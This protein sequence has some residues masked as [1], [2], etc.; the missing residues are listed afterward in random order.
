MKQKYLAL[1][2]SALSSIALARDGTALTL[3]I[4]KVGTEIETDDCPAIGV[5]QAD[6]DFNQHV[7]YDF[8]SFRADCAMRYSQKAVLSPKT[9]L[10]KNT[11]RR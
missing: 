7:G 5:P 2:S 6:V 1:C 4:T 10:L 8:S 9:S 3:L 11:H